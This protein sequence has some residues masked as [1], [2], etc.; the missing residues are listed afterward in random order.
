MSQVH[1]IKLRGIE[2]KGTTSQEDQEPPKV[3]LNALGC[4]EPQLQ[5]TRVAC[6]GPTSVLLCQQCCLYASSW[7][8]KLRGQPAAKKIKNHPRFCSM[9]LEVKSLN[10]GFR[11]VRLG[12]QLSYLQDTRAGCLGPTFVF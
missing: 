7:E 6:L 4:Q 11:S 5:E 8:Q 12:Q 10:D 3:L 1:S 2:T 9:P